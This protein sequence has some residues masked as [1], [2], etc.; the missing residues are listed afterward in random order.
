MKRFKAYQTWK[1]QI[2]KTIQK[3]QRPISFIQQ[4][5]RKY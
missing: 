4:W 2:Q 3:S 1:R 5:R